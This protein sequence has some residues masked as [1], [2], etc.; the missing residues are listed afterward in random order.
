MIEFRYK[1]FSG[2]GLRFVNIQV[3]SSNFDANSFDDNSSVDIS[4][5]KYE[6]NIISLDFSA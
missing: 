4:V 2:R 5:M 6:L 1:F 3:L